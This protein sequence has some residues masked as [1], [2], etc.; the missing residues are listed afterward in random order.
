M[1]FTV[2]LLVPLFPFVQVE[3]GIGGICNIRLPTLQPGDGPKHFL[4]DFCL[5]DLN[6]LTIADPP[7]RLQDV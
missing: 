4:L 6:Y 5:L 3:N 1:S 2:C 7:P